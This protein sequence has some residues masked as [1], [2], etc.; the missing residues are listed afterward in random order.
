MKPIDTITLDL[1]S[2]GSLK[3]SVFS[4]GVKRFTHIP[5]AQSP[6]GTRRWKKPEPLPKEHVY[7]TNGPLDCT[8]YGNVCPQPEYIVN[9]KS[10]I[11]TNYSFNED[12]L[13]VNMWLPPGEAPENGWPILAWIHGGWLQIGDPSLKE[14]T[15]PTQLLSEGGLKAIVISIGYR[16]NIL[17]FLAGK[18]LKGNFGF[19]DQRCALEWIQD[20]ARLLGGD[21][22][23]VTLGG[24]SAGAFST[25]VQLNYE[26]FNGSA[27]KPL[28]N[29][30]W[31]QSNAIP[32]QPKTLDEVDAQLQNVLSTFGISDS[33]S[34]EER[35]DKLREVPASD[36][37]KRIFDFD[38][39]TFR[40]VTDEEM[41]PS[42]LISNIHSGAFAARFKE[43]G[44]RILLGEAETEEV[45]YS[46]TNPPPS[47]SSDDLLRGLNNYYALPVCESLLSLYTKEGSSADKR[48][49]TALSQEDD[50]EKAKQ[51]FGLITSDV[52][53]RAPI[54]VLSKALFDGGISPEQVLRYRVAYRPE[55]TDQV[56]PKSFGVTHAADGVSWWY[57]ERYGFSEQE[58]ECVKQ[59]LGRT[60]IPLVTGQESTKDMPKLKEYLYFKEDG[61]PEV[62]EDE[63][64]D[65]LAR[66]AE[67]LN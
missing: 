6:T 21:P 24:L 29:K 49:E 9:G 47:S 20:Y 40:G 53:V 19:W 32:A 56:Y 10:M 63:H 59:W 42:D 46:L 11:D 14:H 52:Q 22:K 60:L 13:A 48:I 44:M 1:G 45:L 43:R 12:C 66:V 2:H 31:L 4:N 55:C 67:K 28:F 7:G 25:H 27:Q 33:L 18:G 54:R 15:Q 38:I 3:G 41:I 51:L 37:V 16:L 65:W 26:L 36:L 30:V 34:P 64:W 50:A 17:G 58:S 35:L 5:Y 39:H 8:R 57:V 62:V 61:T 23:R